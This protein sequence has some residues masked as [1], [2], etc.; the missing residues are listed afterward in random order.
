MI[1]ISLNSLLHSTLLNFIN[2]VNFIDYF[3]FFFFISSNQNLILISIWNISNFSNRKYNHYI[4]TTFSHR[5]FSYM[6]HKCAK[7]KWDKSL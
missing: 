3:I 7:N 6:T 2:R 5:R 1:L 4:G